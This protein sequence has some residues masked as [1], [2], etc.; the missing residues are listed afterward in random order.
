LDARLKAYGESHPNSGVAPA[1]LAVARALA[2]DAEGAKAALDAAKA[3]YPR[4][5]TNWVAAALVAEILGDAEGAKSAIDALRAQSPLS[6]AAFVP[7]GT[8]G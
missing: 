5:A 7:V 4:L 8:G 1:Y 3:A 2:G 6:A